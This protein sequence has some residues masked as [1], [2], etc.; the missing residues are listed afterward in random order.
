[1]CS[2][3]RAFAVLAAGLLTGC[4]PASGKQS[5]EQVVEVTATTPLVEESITVFANNTHYQ[6]RDEPERQV[7]GV[8]LRV[9]VRTG[10]NTREH[11]I[12]L[13]TDQGDWGVYSE[14]IMP[15]LLDTL[16]D[17]PLCLTGKWVDQSDQGAPIEV[18][19][20]RIDEFVD[21]DRGTQTR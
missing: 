8:L 20:G 11:P 14:G 9:A 19:I 13:Q 1:M 4:L 12:R 21:A 10:P 3:T 15:D 2:R 6:E 7:C 16:V 18:W 17:R 5:G